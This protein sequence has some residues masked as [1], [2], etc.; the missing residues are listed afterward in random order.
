MK[1]ISNEEDRNVILLQRESRKGCLGGPDLKLA[2]REKQSQ[3]QNDHKE[4]YRKKIS[5]QQEV[6][7]VL[8]EDFDE[9]VIESDVDEDLS[10]DVV[11]SVKDR[12]IK[13]RHIIS[14]L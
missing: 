8:V 12:G 9:S 6:S 14:Q 4:T 13:H 11:N 5:T 10:S 7:Q 3:D 1:L 2:M